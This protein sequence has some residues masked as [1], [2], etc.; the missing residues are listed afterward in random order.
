M[1][2]ISTDFITYNTEELV[3]PYCE[4]FL[5]SSGDIEEDEGLFTCVNCGEEFNF[6]RNIFVTYDSWRK[7]D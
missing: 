6:R 4:Y 7:E 1:S 3:C 2:T 5:W